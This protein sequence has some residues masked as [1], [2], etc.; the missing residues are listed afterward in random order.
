MKRRIALILL[1]GV[2]L[3]VMLFAMSPGSALGAGG[4]FEPG[5]KDKAGGKSPD[6]EPGDKDKAGGKAGK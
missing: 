5:D 6:L 1:A 4:A 2:V 3:V